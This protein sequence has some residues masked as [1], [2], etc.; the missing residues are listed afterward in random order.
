MSNRAQSL[1]DQEALTVLCIDIEGGHGGSSR[2]LYHAI[3]AMDLSA[4][5]VSVLCRRSSWLEKSYETLGVA[6]RVER[7]I[8]T[9]TALFRNSRS[10]LTRVLFYPRVWY[11]SRAFR[12]RLLNE[13][14]DVDILHLNHISLSD[15]ARWVRR[16]RPDMRIVMHIRT[17]PYT[18]AFA[19]SQARAA[20]LACDAFIFI[21]ENERDHFEAQSQARVRGAVIYNPVPLLPARI[22]THPVQ[23]PV[24][25][26]L[27]VACLSN[28]SYFRGLDRLIDVAAA[29]TE[30]ER[31]RITF[32]IAGDMRLSKPIPAH[33]AKSAPNA[34][35]LMDIVK[36]CGV[37]DCFEFHGHVADPERIL[38]GCD[39]LIKPTRENNPWGRDILE[40]MGVGIPVVSVGG[41]SHF[42]ESGQTGLLQA[43]FDAHEVVR[44]LIEL[45]DTP[46][47]RQEMG[48][49]ARE[50]IRTL[51]D[52]AKIADQLHSA[53]SK[54][55]ANAFS[56]D[57]VAGSFAAT[58]S[59]QKS[60]RIRFAG[61]LPSFS[62]GGAERV[63]VSLCA[64]LSSR[65]FE[66]RLFVLSEDGKLTADMSEIGFVHTLGTG[67]LSQS[68]WT[69]WRMIRGFHRHVVFSSQAHL[70][71]ALLL[72]K[73]VLPG[74]KIVV[75]EANM[76]SLCLDS[77]H[78]PRWYKLVYGAALRLADAV[79]ASSHQMKQDIETVFNV[80]AERVVT[81]YNPVDEGGLRRR[82]CSPLRSP[83]GGPRF[84][85][86]GRLVRQKGF[87][88]LIDWFGEAP[89]DAQ[90]DI[91]GE[92]PDHAQLEARI[93]QRGLTDRVR[94]RGFCQDPAPQIAGA[95]ALLMASHWEGM[96]NVALEALALGVPVIATAQSGAI[97]EIQA[98]ASPG[99]VTIASDGAAFIA[100]LQAVALDGSGAL[101]PSLL[102]AVFAGETVAHDFAELIRRL[103]APTDSAP[104]TGE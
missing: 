42:V 85:A 43:R 91:F 60:P 53:W 44:F 30:R 103:V 45:A 97:A 40:A 17:M 73:P 55:A 48:A 64:G 75:R 10:L 87:E 50:R 19:S 94:M 1:S 14:Q 69:L 31:A 35:T 22:G 63:L 16:K 76:P 99:A 46:T 15:L 101:R 93:A 79:I 56:Q 3:A 8:P 74:V 78:W 52:P 54:I 58:S 57:P 49:R 25:T 62:A 59:G 90:L 20:A 7:A 2:S 84:V 86:V 38:Q 67:R 47:R 61:L 104:K 80:P 71:I 29:M 13:L 92:G 39:V 89:K 41:H 95:D 37:D 83:G 4:T 23:S 96:P 9:W 65:D 100:G 28:Y 66:T 102:P 5:R 72:M 18:S 98:K 82:A 77:G 32:V 81:L 24:A 11:R 33:L 26:G 27:R 88:R 70:N 51:S 21:T 12:A 36:S 34:V 68:V 6:C